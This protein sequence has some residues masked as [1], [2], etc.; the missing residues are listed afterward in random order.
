MPTKVGYIGRTNSEVGW[1][2]YDWRVPV[3][4]NSSH[5]LTIHECNYR[6]GAKTYEDSYATTTDPVVTMDVDEYPVSIQF[7]NYAGPVSGWYNLD[8][9]RT[10]SVNVFLCHSIGQPVYNL[11]P[12]MSLTVSPNANI[13]D[14]NV[15]TIQNGI[16]LAGRALDIYVDGDRQIC[17]RRQCKATITTDYLAYAVGTVCGEHGSLTV[18][19]STAKRG[20]SVTVTVT[21]DPDYQLDSITVSS[22]TLV[23]VSDN[24]YTFVM[25]SPA[26][27]VTITA[28]F[29]EGPHKTV[30]YYD[31]S[32]FVEC[33]ASVYDN[34]EFVETE[35]YYYNGSAWVPCSHTS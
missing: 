12:V 33:I 5:N 26:R 16:A 10:G 14:T 35:P 25:P 1:W 32:E 28:T 29:A 6:P 8:A 34:G 22:G 3:A 9:S 18:S 19:A 13:N 31:G 21:P 23:Q 17:L 30:K 11:T 20:S 7:S 2:D 27:N 4:V 15:H 24:V